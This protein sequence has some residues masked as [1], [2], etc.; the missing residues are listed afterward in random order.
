MDKDLA[1]LVA[2][3]AFRSSS[4][5]SNLIPLL[6]EKCE[7]SE[8]QIFVKAIAR[9]SG[10]IGQQLMFRVF[11]EHPDLEKEFDEMVKKYGRPF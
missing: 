9:A 3:T 6:R 11:V 8:Y 4:E 2:I 5:I 7:D 10:E 1:K